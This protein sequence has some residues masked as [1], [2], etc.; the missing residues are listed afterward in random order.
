MNTAVNGGSSA[1]TAMAGVLLGRLPLAG[2][3][4]AALPVLLTAVLALAAT[5]P[6]TPVS[7]RERIHR[8]VRRRSGSGGARRRR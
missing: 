8:A 3:A 7:A 1:G 2:F 5:R 4:V 6:I